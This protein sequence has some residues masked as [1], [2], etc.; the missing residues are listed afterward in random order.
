MEAKR[1]YAKT[2]T[3]NRCSHP[4]EKWIVARGGVSAWVCHQHDE[5]YVELAERDVDMTHVS[6]SLG[7]TIRELRKIRGWS[8]KDV[9]DRAGVNRNLIGRIE[10]CQGATTMK[11]LC[12]LASV[13]EV[14]AWKLLKDA[15]L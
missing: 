11:P 3:G 6:E 2:S 7:N 10:N 15:G 13:F 1:C 14:P 12:K 4:G 8:Q 9:A 5:R